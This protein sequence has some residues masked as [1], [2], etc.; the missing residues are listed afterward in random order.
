MK[1]VYSTLLFFTII[2]TERN[3]RVPIPTNHRTNLEIMETG[4]AR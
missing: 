4:S 1:S 3:Y 2:R